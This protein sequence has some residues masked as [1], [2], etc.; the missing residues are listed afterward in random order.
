MSYRRS[1]AHLFQRLRQTEAGDRHLA[2]TAAQKYVARMHGAVA[3]PLL[4]CSIDC[5]RNGGEEPLDVGKTKRRRL[6]QMDVECI[7]GEVLEHHEGRAAFDSAI[8]R[9]D[10]AGHTRR[11]GGDRAQSLSETRGVFGYQVEFEGFDCDQPLAGRVVRTKNRAQY[12][13]AN[14]MQDAIR[15]KRRRRAYAGQIVKWQCGG[16]LRTG[17]RST[18][19]VD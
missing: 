19:V 1:G 15:G 4:P 7:A 12:A 14:L 17:N 16:S 10:Q 8:H 6:A 3:D 2:Q 9:R 11:A 5:A 18:S 13:A